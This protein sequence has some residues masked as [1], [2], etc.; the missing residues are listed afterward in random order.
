MGEVAQLP[1]WY[2]LVLGAYRRGDALENIEAALGG[3]SSV[4]RRRVQWAID[5]A[6]RQER[7]NKAY[8]SAQYWKGRPHAW[9]AP[10]HP[11]SLARRSVPC[12]SE[13]QA[14]G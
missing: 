9:A 13:E 2:H 6:L 1:Q 11:V 5:H 7:A 14:D 8:V 10:R 4:A 12:L 3:P